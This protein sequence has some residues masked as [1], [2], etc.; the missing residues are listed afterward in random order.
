MLMFRGTTLNLYRTIFSF[1][2]L[3]LVFLLSGCAKSD[4]LWGVV[5]KVCRVNYQQ[6][7]DPAPCT[8]IY[9][10]TQDLQHGFTVIQ[11]PRFHYH[12][13]LVPNTRMSGI[14][15]P[16]LLPNDAPD[17]FGY[18]WTMRQ[19]LAYEYGKPI[20][21]DVLGLALN[22]AYGRSQNQLHIHLTCLREDVRRQLKAERPFIREQW[23]L[24]PDTLLRHAFYAKRV[25]QPTLMGVYPI[26]SLAEQ[27][28]LTPEQLA[29][30]GVAIVPTTFDTQPGFILLAT[31]VGMGERNRASVESLLD[32]RC[33]LLQAI[34][35]Q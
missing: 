9:S 1:V 13:I 35:A 24:L 23:T 30:Y 15:S 26:R 20:P 14:E 22:S 17:Y 34:P 28:K 16:A 31:R 29:Y 19:R 10:P 8:Q 2:P 25:V 6:K 32:K 18:A 21:D 12:F 3:I 27:F 33:E 11:N 7:H 4:A 5:D